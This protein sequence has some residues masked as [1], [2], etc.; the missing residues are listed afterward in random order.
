MHSPAPRAKKTQKTEATGGAGGKS[1]KEGR[2]YIVFFAFSN[3][4][5]FLL[6]ISTS[7]LGRF[8]SR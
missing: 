4:T 6:V 7:P 5:P 8:F 1:E 2:G 3:N